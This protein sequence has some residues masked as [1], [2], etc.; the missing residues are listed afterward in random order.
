MLTI[1]VHTLSVQG[2]REKQAENGFLSKAQM[3]N[4]GVLLYGMGNSRGSNRCSLSH[5]KKAQV[6]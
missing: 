5:E 6:W 1:P 3:V 4:K 2:R